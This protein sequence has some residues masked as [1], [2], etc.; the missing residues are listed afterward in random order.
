MQDIDNH[1]D[2]LFRKAV[3]NYTLQSGES[4]WDNIVSQISDAPASIPVEINHKK[5]NTTNGG[6]ILLVLLLIPLSTAMFSWYTDRGTPKH[7][8]NTADL[9][10]IYPQQQRNNTTSSARKNIQRRPASVTARATSATVPLYSTSVK[11]NT[12]A[13]TG[14][15]QKKNT[16]EVSIKNPETIYSSINPNAL[17]EAT[18]SATGNQQNDAGNKQPI[19][20]H[21][22]YRQK[23]H[24]YVGLTAGLAFNEVKN[25]GFGKP[26]FDIGIIGGYRVN[27]NISIETGLVYSTKYYFSNGK[28]F[29]MDKMSGSMPADMKVLSLEGS[30]NLYQVPVAIK[31]D[32]VHRKAS[33]FFSSAGISSYILTKEKNNYQ[34][35]MNG[36][37]QNMQGM[38]KNVS[39]GFA[40]SIDLSIGY[41]HTLRKGTNIR[42][43]PYLQVPLKG[44]GIGSM[45]VLSTGLHIAYVK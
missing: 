39:A 37:Q 40:S 42:I 4:N 41:E 45:Q 43:Q 25:Q 32:V 13:I 9:L 27:R 8:G 10:S 1:M 28:Y 23:P 33:A 20:T 21:A 24:L 17:P 22:N 29:S 15:K 6:I 26:G 2:D 36:M 12:L 34:T 31:Y 5:N 11:T 35:S 38:Y 18:R 19:T 3:D 7:A 30:S 44:M 14:L 16:A